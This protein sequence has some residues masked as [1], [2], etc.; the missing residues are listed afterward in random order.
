MNI[1][2]MHTHDT[3]RNI[4]PYGYAVPTPNLKGLAEEG[5]LFRQAF[6]AGPTCSPS[7][8]GLLTGMAPHTAGMLGLA[9]RGFHMEDYTRHLASFLTRHGYETALCGVQH[10]V[11]EA[12]IGL[13]GYTRNLTVLNKEQEHEAK[14]LRTA[15]IAADFIKEQHDQPFF[16][17]VG[18]FNTHRAKADFPETSHP[19]DPRYVM[20]P[21]P[22]YDTPQNREDMAAFT[23]SAAVVDQCYGIVRQALEESGQWDN[24]ILLFT[25]DHGIAFP[26]MK[27]NLLDTGIGVSLIMHVPGME[28]GK[29]VDA[30]V[31]QVDLFPTLCELSRIEKPDWLQGASM[32]PLMDGSADEIRGELFAEVTYHA[33]YEPMRCIRT[34]RYKLIRRYTDHHQHVMP[35]MDDGLSKRFLVSHGMREQRTQQEMLFD[36]YLDPIER[37]NLINDPAYQEI[38]EDLSRRLLGWMK[39]TN[40]P[41][42]ETAEVPLPGG[43]FA[44]PIHELNP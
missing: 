13:L 38:A 36:L 20:P 43:A 11:A 24:T 15:H 2:Y 1:I 34:K 25:T 44:T 8:A 28:K 35:N 6:C 7:R 39:E 42:L 9:H 23:A 5:I 32:V 17:S 22:M 16:A 41:L 19:V 18:L 21:F 33:A 27:C 30:I 4:E 29:V 12:Q 40:D 3:G 31:S 14:D 10:E 26:R 37:E